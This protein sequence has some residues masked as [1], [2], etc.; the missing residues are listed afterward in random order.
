MSRKLL[1]AATLLSTVLFVSHVQAADGIVRHKIPNSDFPISLAV[2]IPASV[3][4]VNLSGAV[5]KISDGDTEA[6]TVSVLQSIEATLKSL[7]LAMKDVI[8]MQVFLVGDSAKAGKMDFEGFMKGYTQFFGTED[9]P[10]LPTRSVF[11]VAGLANPDWLVEI[12]V[13]AV[14]P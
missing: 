5:P 11:Q 6:Q 12:E 14:R 7:N 8:K 3:T 9:Q 13:T 1:N 10:N 4:V 2:E